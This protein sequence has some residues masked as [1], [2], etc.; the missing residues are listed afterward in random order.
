MKSTDLVQKLLDE[1]PECVVI[2]CVGENQDAIGAELEV[3]TEYSY[4][5]GS[6]R[7]VHWL[8]AKS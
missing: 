1:D 8:H 7:K 2:N 6:K 5:L 3:Q 4:F